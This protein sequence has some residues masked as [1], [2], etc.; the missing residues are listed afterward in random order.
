[1]LDVL[2]VLWPKTHGVRIIGSAVL[3]LA[4][5]ACGRMSLYV[6]R[7]LFPWDLAAGTLLV[8]EARGVVTDWQGCE[9]SVYTKEIAAANKAINRKFIELIRKS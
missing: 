7:N 1:M 8:R 9:A 2:G 4:Y 3:G 6:H 5:V